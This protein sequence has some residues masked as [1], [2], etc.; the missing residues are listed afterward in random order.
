MPRGRPTV[1]TPAMVKKI[2]DCFLVAFN[3]EQTALYCGIDPKTIWKIRKGDLFPAVKIAEL[4][5]EMKYR[6]KV[7]NA[8]GFW[9]GAAWFLERK[10]PTQFA[11]PEIQLQVNTQF[12]SVTAITITAPEAG[13][14]RGRLEKVDHR[15]D[16]FLSRRKEDS[17]HSNGNGNQ[18]TE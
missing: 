9:Q 13:K 6:I 3:D 8:K 4:Q 18:A 7:W 12:N 15:I 17:E 1:L 11:K 2:A 14:I 10:Y 5:R 16:Q